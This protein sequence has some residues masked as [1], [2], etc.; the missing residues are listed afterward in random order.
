MSQ[1]ESV[2]KDNFVISNMHFSQFCMLPETNH[3]L[4]L[5]HLLQSELKC[6]FAPL[7]VNLEGFNLAH[8]G[9]GAA[10]KD[11]ATEC[12]ALHLASVISNYLVL[13]LNDTTSPSNEVTGIPFVGVERRW[14]SKSPFGGAGNIVAQFLRPHR[15]SELSLHSVSSDSHVISGKRAVAGACSFLRVPAWL[16]LCVEVI[17]QCPQSLSLL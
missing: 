15:P 3:V 10:V 13:R 16:A 7:A 8:L 17:S 9:D 11:K 14:G 6:H 5:L 2:F 1:I 12:S 4:W